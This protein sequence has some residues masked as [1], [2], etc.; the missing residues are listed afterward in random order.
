MFEHAIDFIAPVMSCRMC[1]YHT[2][3]GDRRFQDNG[4]WGYKTDWLLLRK[5]GYHNFKH[6]DIH[7]TVH[8]SLPTHCI[9]HRMM[10]KNHKRIDTYCSTPQRLLTISLPTDPIFI[11]KRYH[12]NEHNMTSSYAGSILFTREARYVHP[13]WRFP[14]CPMRAMTTVGGGL[15]SSYP[16][17]F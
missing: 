9:V 14:L 15:S 12:A 13:S 4:T 2:T 16:I 3:N 8:T 6:V 17:P 10:H 1:V 11:Q 5:L 7:V